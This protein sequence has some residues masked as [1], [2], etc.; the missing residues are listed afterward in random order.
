M[1]FLASNSL[2]VEDKVM[3]RYTVSNALSFSFHHLQRDLLLLNYLWIVMS[4]GSFGF[5]LI[6][7]IF[8]LFFVW[9]LIVLM[10]I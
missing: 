1:D 2:L 3:S 6:A 7:V 4:A 5:S 10:F 9:L 8:L